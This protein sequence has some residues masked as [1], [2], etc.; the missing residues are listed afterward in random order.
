MSFNSLLFKVV[1]GTHLQITFC[2]AKCLLYMPEIMIMLN[3]NVITDFRLRQICVIA[4]D[5]K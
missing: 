1:D 5:A 2:N 4:F 3:S